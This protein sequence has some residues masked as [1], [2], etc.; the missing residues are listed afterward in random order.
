MTERPFL[1]TENWRLYSSLLRK[2]HDIKHT[3]LQSHGYTIDGDT[4]RPIDDEDWTI[5]EETENLRRARSILKQEK[6]SLPQT[7]VLLRA[8]RYIEAG[9]PHTYADKNGK[10]GYI[11]M[12]GEDDLPLQTMLHECVHLMQK[13]TGQAEELYLNRANIEVLKEKELQ[14]LRFNPDA[15][16]LHLQRGAT[17]MLCTEEKEDFVPLENE[18]YT[19]AAWLM[20]RVRLGYYNLRY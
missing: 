1:Q 19:T 5:I 4:I 13:F 17:N 8:P 7:V 15:N 10:F 16:P 3:L 2:Q 18:A 12:P 20:S 11:V 6:L 9:C 14:H